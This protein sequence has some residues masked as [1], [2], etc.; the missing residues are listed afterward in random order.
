MVVGNAWL[1]L[2]FVAP[3]LEGLGKTYPLPLYKLE[4]PLQLSLTRIIWGL[5]Y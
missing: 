2:D 1:L 4:N 3:M 5:K